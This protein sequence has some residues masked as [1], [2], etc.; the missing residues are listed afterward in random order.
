MPTRRVSFKGSP[1]SLVYSASSSTPASMASLRTPSPTR[2]LAS[3]TL[4]EGEVQAWKEAAKEKG[5]SLEEYMDE[6]SKED[7]DKLVEERMH[8]IVEEEK[9]EAKQ[10]EAEEGSRR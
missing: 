9:G 1:S 3:P 10:P 7:L 4:S 2:F 6:I 8:G 5:L